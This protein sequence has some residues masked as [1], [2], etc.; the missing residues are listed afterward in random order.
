MKLRKTSLFLIIFWLILAG[1]IVWFKVLPNGHIT[2]YRSYPAK[3]NIFGG[4][5]FIGNLTPADRVNDKNENGAEIF[6][7]PV[8]F[9]VFTPRTF[10]DAKITI[11]YQDNL[12]TSTPLIEAGVLVD[13]IVWRY[14]LAS[15]ENKLLDN[16][17]SSWSKI[18]EDGVLLLQKN[19]KFSTILDFLNDVKNKPEEIC[20]TNNLQS[21]LALYNTE[22]FSEYFGDNNNL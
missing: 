22:K 20:Q 6:G 14:K 21:C 16:N 7:D 18:Q 13:N 4:K 15:L 8:Y 3:I 12:T 10:N 2:Y 19:K 1:L 11:T 17:F 5:G 9:S